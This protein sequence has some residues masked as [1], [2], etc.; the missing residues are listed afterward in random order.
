MSYSAT[1]SGTLVLRFDENAINGMKARMQ[2]YY[3]ELFQKGVAAYRPDEHMM[4]VHRSVYEAE[5]EALEKEQPTEWLESALSA[6]G[7]SDIHFTKQSELQL[8]YVEMEFDAR[9]RE[10]TILKLL[11]A[12]SPQTITGDFSFC[13]EDNGVWRLVF[14][15]TSWHE[16]RGEIVYK[17]KAGTEPL[18]QAPDASEEKWEALLAQIQSL[19]QS[20]PR[21]AVQRGYLLVNA[22]Q[23]QEPDGVLAALTGWSMQALG[24]FV[25]LWSKEDAS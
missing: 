17:D 1:G 11:E 18:Q 22:V 20:D 5:K 14:I 6:V 9:Y 2:V 12:L 19:V 13:G 23:A 21:P 15:G 4:Q 16:Q 24:A 8:L 3:D 10:D 7:F 25:E